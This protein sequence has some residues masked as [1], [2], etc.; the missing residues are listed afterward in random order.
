MTLLV[1]YFGYIKVLYKTFSKL[2]VT[3][4]KFYPSYFIVLLKIITNDISFII[5]II[6]SYLI[7]LITL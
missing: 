6:F 3:T 4:L 7:S 2:I 5:I 1:V